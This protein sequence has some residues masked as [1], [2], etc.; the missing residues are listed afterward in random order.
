MFSFEFC[1]ISKNTFFYRTPLLAASEHLSQRTLARLCIGLWIMVN[2][3]SPNL[4]KNTN[5]ANISCFPRRL[6]DVFS[7]SLFVFQDLLKTTPRRL[8]DI[9][10]I[11]VPKTSSRRLQDVFKT[12]LQEVV[13]L[14]LQDVLESS[15]KTK[16]VTLKT[17]SVRLHQD[18]CLLG[19]FRYLLCSSFKIKLM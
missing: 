17:S 16:N 11:R 9:F 5:P 6:Q 2:Y 14:C 10:A 13:Q 15:W 18:K 4:K 3:V 12:C 7:I 19:R 1:E 8:Q